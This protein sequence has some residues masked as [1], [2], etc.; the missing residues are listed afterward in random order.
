MQDVNHQLFT[1]SVE[2]EITLSMERED[3]TQLQSLLEEFDLLELREKHPMALSGGQKQRVA[4]ASAIASGRDFIAF[5]EPTSGLD[6]LHLQQV[7][8]CILN[9]QRQGK[10]ILLITHDLELIYACCSYILHLENGK[11]EETYP[12]HAGTE[13]KLRKFFLPQS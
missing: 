3:Q 1:Q 10:T 6:H 4:V 8:E 12:L 9:L 7:A 2:E 11:I 5:D 13:P